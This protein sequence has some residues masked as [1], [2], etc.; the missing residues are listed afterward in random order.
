MVRIAVD[1]FPEGTVPGPLTPGS[2]KWTAIVALLP[3]PMPAVPAQTDGCTQG[4]VSLTAILRDGTSLTYGPCG[5]PV[6][7]RAA[8]DAMFTP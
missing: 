8:A 2:P 5:F 3:E 1:V 4:S 6:D 7:L